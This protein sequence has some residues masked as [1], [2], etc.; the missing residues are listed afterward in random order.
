[1]SFRGKCRPASW[2][3]AVL[4]KDTKTGWILAKAQIH[5]HWD[6]I[7]MGYLILKK[8]LLYF[9]ALRNKTW[10]MFMV[11]SL[12]SA[13]PNPMFNTCHKWA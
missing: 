4:L 9:C 1:M 8:L 13:L 7:E 11:R 3:H 2:W 6:I 5:V 10:G 12:T